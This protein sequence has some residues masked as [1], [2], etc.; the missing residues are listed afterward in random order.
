MLTTAIHLSAEQEIALAQKARNGDLS[1][2]AHELQRPI[3]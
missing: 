2:M 1:D 3:A